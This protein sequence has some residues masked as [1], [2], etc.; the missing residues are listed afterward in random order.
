MLNLLGGKKELGKKLEEG[1]EPG[2]GL[3]LSVGLWVDLSKC[4]A[5]CFFLKDI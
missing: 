1:S 3:K 4:L 2:I 5:E